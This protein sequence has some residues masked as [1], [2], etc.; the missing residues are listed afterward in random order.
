MADNWG[1]EVHPQKGA[2]RRALHIQ[3]GQKI[4]VME[5]RAILASPVGSRYHGISVTQ[6]LKEQIDFH[7]N[8]SG[9][10]KS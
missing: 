8:I 10:G 3:E 4:P 9:K 2:L 1:Q 7:L 5:E 6:K